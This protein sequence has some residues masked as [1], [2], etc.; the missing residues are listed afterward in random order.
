MKIEEHIG[1]VKSIANKYKGMG[2]DF[3]DLVQ[4]GTIGLMQAMEKY[5]KTKGRFSTFAYHCIQ[6]R[7]FAT[8]NNS[9]TIRVPRGAIIHKKKL[10]EA[11]GNNATDLS[12][13]TGLSEKRIKDIEKIEDVLSIDYVYSGDL[14]LNDTISDNT[15][16]EKE[17]DKK[18]LKETIDNFFIEGIECLSG[19]ERGVVNLLCGFDGVYMTESE[20][21]I[22]WDI[23]RERVRQL[24]NI[25][26]AKMLKFKPFDG[27]L[28][29]EL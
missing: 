6:N 29:T 11:K 13:E 18:L 25:A 3:D 17:F 20:I 23:S 2:I 19:R 9:R 26:I 14:S 21:A 16:L 1:L 24:K 15:N 28:L 5:D 10:E 4:E 27:R 12:K 22:E 7:I 8:L